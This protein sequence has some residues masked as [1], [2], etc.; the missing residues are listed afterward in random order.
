MAK[1]ENKYPE[2]TVKIINQQKKIHKTFLEYGYTDIPADK[3]INGSGIPGIEL[4]YFV[5][6]MEPDTYSYGTA[7]GVFVYKDDR[8]YTTGSRPEL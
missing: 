2:E 3:I 7:C 6:C 8:V 1:P 4:L 5:A